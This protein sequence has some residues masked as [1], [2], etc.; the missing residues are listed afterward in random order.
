MASVAKVPSAASSG[1]STD[2]DLKKL[3]IENQFLK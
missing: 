2:K 1:T 3:R